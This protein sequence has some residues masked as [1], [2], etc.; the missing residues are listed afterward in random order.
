MA[1]DGGNIV[2]DDGSPSRKLSEWRDSGGPFVSRRE[3]PEPDYPEV[4]YPDGTIKPV[5]PRCQSHW[6]ITDRAQAAKWRKWAA[7]LTWF[8]TFPF[9]FWTAPLWLDSDL[10]RMCKT[11]GYRFVRSQTAD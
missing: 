9:G 2:N 4:L 6:V 8:F 11:C 5:C 10:H 1:C 3:E 7:V